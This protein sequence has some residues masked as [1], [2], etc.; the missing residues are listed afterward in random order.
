M[1]EAFLFTSIPDLYFDEYMADT[2]KITD[3]II[4]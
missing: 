4:A 1:V 2:E 3:Q